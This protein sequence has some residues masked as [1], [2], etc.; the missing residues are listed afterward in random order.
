MTVEKCQELKLPLMVEKND[1]QFS[2][3][4]TVSIEAAQGVTTGISA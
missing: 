4:F 2:T 1:A 3:N